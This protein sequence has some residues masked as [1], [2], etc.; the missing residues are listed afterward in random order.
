MKKLLSLALALVMVLTLSVAVA[1]AEPPYQNDTSVT[2]GI[3][4][5]GENGAVQT[6]EETFVYT[7][8]DGAMIGGRQVI[9]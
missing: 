5:N 7:I 8:N 9:I 2:I 4:F 6:P 3:A 1:A